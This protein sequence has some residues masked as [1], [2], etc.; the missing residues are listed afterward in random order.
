MP[1]SYSVFV[2]TQSLTKGQ[3][4]GITNSIELSL[5]VLVHTTAAATG[6]SIIIQKSAIA[7]FVVKGFGAVYLFYLAYKAMKEKKQS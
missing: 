2:F 5:G 4:N 3:R 7:F 1:G 6:L